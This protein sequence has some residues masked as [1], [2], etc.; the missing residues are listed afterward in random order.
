MSIYQRIIQAAT[1]C[2]EADLAPIEEIMRQDI[3]HS[4][5]DWQGEAVLTEA[6]REAAYL[7]SEFRKAGY[8]K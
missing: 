4:T 8:Y 6:A 2:P 1:K 3:F 5:L 7:L